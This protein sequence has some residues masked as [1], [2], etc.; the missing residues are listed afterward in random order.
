MK[1]G[2]RGS[3]DTRE[4]FGLRRAPRGRAGGAVARARGRRAALRA[5]PAQSDD[6]RRRLPAG[7]HAGRQP[8]PASAPACLAMRVA[9]CIAIIAGSHR[10]RCQASS[11]R[12]RRSSCRSAAAAGT[13]TSSSTERPSATRHTS[14]STAS[15]PG[16]FRTMGTPL[17]AGRDFD[18]SRTPSVRRAGR[19]SSP[20]CSRRSSSTDADPIG[21]LF[22]IEEAPASSG[23]LYEIVGW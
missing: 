1:A 21:R 7:R 15:S 11:R 16:Y 22:Q 19:R 9:R 3:T 12:R 14:T 13:T 17:L 5:Q 20:S 18:G 8:R 6:A 23:R 4:R 2:S 10:R